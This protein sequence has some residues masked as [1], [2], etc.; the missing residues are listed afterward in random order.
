M[1]EPS[2]YPVWPSLKHFYGEYRSHRKP[3]VLSEWGVSNGDDPRFI[4]KVF[5]F[6][7][8]HSATR[9]LVYYQDFG[10]SNRYRIQ[11]YPKSRKLA[12]ALFYKAKTLQA[13][14]RPAESRA[15]C[16][17]LRRKF[18]TNDFAKQCAVARQ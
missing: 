8:Q 12:E 15:A 14:N 18:P 16:Q 1:R 11:N 9:M 5:S 10:T 2:Q 7:R 3:F 13:L 17:E 4:K 6:V